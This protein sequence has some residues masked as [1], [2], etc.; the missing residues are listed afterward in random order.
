MSNRAGNANS[1][2]NFTFIMFLIF[3]TIGSLL[4]DIRWGAMLVLVL[5]VSVFVVPRRFKS[6]LGTIAVISAGNL[7]MVVGYESTILENFGLSHEMVL[8]LN[9][10]YLLVYVL[11]MILLIAGLKEKL[12]RPA[13]GNFRAIIKLPF[14]WYG[15]NV[16]VWKFVLIAS[17]ANIIV[18]LA[19]IDYSIFISGN[20]MKV[21]MYSFLFAFVNSVLEET[22]W[23]GLIMPRYIK[24]FGEKTGLIVISTIFGL[25]HYSFGLP[26]LV[27]LAYAAGGMYMG[28]LVIRSGGLLPILIFHFVLNFWMF[29]SFIHRQFLP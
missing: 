21:V 16:P 20:I 3:V 13:V 17:S 8:I 9:R 5:S 12:P 18:F 14:I 22:V 1:L 26:W 23:R 29:F 27:C 15:D 4:A 19:F 7:A 11:G 6:I 24:F 10:L 25:Y 28:A 2:L